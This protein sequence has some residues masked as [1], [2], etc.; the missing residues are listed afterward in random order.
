MFSSAK[1][2]YTSTYLSIK[3]GSQE[4]AAIVANMNQPDFSES[5]TEWLKTVH[6][7]P[8]GFDFR[9]ES[10]ASIL[11]LNVQSLF[12]F[13]VEKEKQICN[14]YKHMCKFS[15]TYE[16]FEESWRKRLNSL[17]FAITIYL[18]EPSGLTSTKFFIEK[19]SSDCRFTI[20]NYISP[21]WSEIKSGDQE[22]HISFNLNLDE[23]FKNST[24]SNKFLIKKNDEIY[25]TKKEDFWLARRSKTASYTHQ[26]AKLIIEP[27]KTYEKNLINI[28]G[29]ALEYNEKDATVT[30]ANFS[31]ALQNFSRS[32]DCDFQLVKNELNET[33][34]FHYRKIFKRDLE[35]FMNVVDKREFN[36]HKKCKYTHKNLVLTSEFIKNFDPFW[37]KYWNRVIGVVDY[38]DP[39]QAV[40]RTWDLK[41]AVL[42]CQVKWSN[43]LM[44]VLSKNEK[45]GKCLKFTAATEGELFLVIATT[46][47]DQNTWYI[48]Q[49][50]TRGVIFYKV[51]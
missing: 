34:I 4:V 17:K 14:E 33:I 21:Y 6:D 44:M 48:F 45:E 36:I 18:K 51:V 2:Q 43:N 10:I 20:L 28:F 49:I 41:F 27:F 25:F 12:G 9:F 26:S 38:V 5:F 16:Q 47:S 30:V 23:P 1:S 50:T 32:I 37:T 3:G 19:G 40:I 8:K 24:T 7:Y 15:L 22:F 35:G 31:L 42:P 46:P 39:I 29:L 11:D 13:S